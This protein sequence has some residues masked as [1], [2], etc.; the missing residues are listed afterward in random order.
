MQT[1]AS[2]SSS[3]A[4]TPRQANEISRSQTI[5]AA[6]IRLSKGLVFFSRTMPRRCR[7][8]HAELSFC[9]QR[10]LQT[11]LRR[12]LHLPTPSVGTITGASTS[13]W[14][15]LLRT[16]CATADSPLRNSLFQSRSLPLLHFFLALPLSTCCGFSAAA[17][18]GHSL[19]RLSPLTFRPECR[20][21]ASFPGAAPPN[22]A[23]RPARP[24]LRRAPDPATHRSDTG[25]F[26]AQSRSDRAGIPRLAAPFV[27]ET[28]YLA[29]L[30]RNIL[31]QFRKLASFHAIADFPPFCRILRDLRRRI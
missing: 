20:A 30:R 15:D 13:R 17:A 18:G 16:H 7:S 9:P 22:V 11:H 8:L 21:A 5:N 1:P 10:S 24:S 14:Y 28:R 6:K 4:S 12:F 27:T 2:H 26:R 29:V 19:D 23:P 31:V 3:G 25:P